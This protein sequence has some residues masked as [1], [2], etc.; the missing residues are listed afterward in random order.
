MS[1]TQPN[2]RLLRLAWLIEQQAAPLAT[3]TLEHVRDELAI[4]DGFPAAGGDQV[5]VSGIG[6]RSTVEAAMMARH[7][8]TGAREQMR[9][10]IATLET[11]VAD[12]V[13]MLRS[14][15]G[16]RVPRYIPEPCDGK[17]RGYEGHELPWTPHSRDPHNGWHDPACRDAADESGLCTRCKPRMNRW[18]REHGFGAI[19]VEAAA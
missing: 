19:G 9:D 5:R 10:D 17:A 15:L 3:L 6:P 7:N 8:L 13:H 2:A 18:R 4:I 12:F 11:M 1:R 14:T 16:D